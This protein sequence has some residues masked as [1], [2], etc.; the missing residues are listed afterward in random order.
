MHCPPLILVAI[1]KENPIAALAGPAI[2]N[3]TIQTNPTTQITHSLC[4]KFE[5]Q[6]T[7]PEENY[8]PSLRTKRLIDA[9]MP[10]P[11]QK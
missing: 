2:D 3:E 7:T 11:N 8:T 1:P 4:K 10:G 5:P 9:C 6:S